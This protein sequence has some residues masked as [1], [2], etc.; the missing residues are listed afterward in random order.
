[1]EKGSIRR[2]FLKEWTFTLVLIAIF[3]NV[4][5]KKTGITHISL[6]KLLF[7]PIIFIVAHFIDKKFAKY[8]S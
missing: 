2:I 1:M 7:I 5:I 8:A 4:Y 3:L 6:L